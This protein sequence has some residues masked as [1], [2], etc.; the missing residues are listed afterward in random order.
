MHAR[1]QELQAVNE[2]SFVNRH[3][4]M[5]NDFIVIGPTDD[6]AKIK[7]MGS[8]A[9]AFAAIAKKGVFLFPGGTARARIPVNFP[10]GRVLDSR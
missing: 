1:E 2:G 8:A 10:S 3:D 5:C 6:P 9:E 4:V 7:G